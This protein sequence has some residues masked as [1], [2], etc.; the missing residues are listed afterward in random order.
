MRSRRS[1]KRSR[2]CRRTTGSR[3]ESGRNPP[4][5][6]PAAG[7]THTPAIGRRRTPRSPFWPS[8]PHRC[9]A[10]PRRS[11][12]CRLSPWSAPV[13]SARA[14]STPAW[15]LRTYRQGTGPWESDNRR[16][17]YSRWCQIPKPRGPPWSSIAS[18]SPCPRDRTEDGRCAISEIVYTR[19]DGAGALAQFDELTEIHQ[20]IY[21]EPPYN[22][23]PKYDRHQFITAAR[24]LVP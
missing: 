15:R 12:C 6:T 7:S 17:T 21:A 24:E 2:A 8:T 9:A 22:N 14:F 4:C 3:H 23:A 11:S 5:S 16:P 10:R 13:T 19:T 18:T 1:S 20:K